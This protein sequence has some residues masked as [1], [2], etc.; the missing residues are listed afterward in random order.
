MVKEW[1]TNSWLTD[2]DKDTDE[3]ERDK[4]TDEEEFQ[5]FAGFP[6]S[7]DEMKWSFLFTIIRFEDKKIYIDH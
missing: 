4:D 7:K 3:E 5:H 6:K 1:K 2:E